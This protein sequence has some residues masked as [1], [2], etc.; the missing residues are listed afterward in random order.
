MDDRK[1]KIIIISV[2][3][4]LFVGAFLIY[5]GWHNTLTQEQVEKCRVLAKQ[6]GEKYSYSWCWEI[7]KPYS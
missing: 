3:A 1:K 6:I 4:G 7:M 5:S 2:I